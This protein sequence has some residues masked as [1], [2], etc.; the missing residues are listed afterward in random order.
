[1][2]NSNKLKIFNDPIYGFIRIPS[3]LIFNLIEDPYFQRLRRIS[4][5]GLSYLVYP[6]AHH[7]RFHHALGSMHLMQQAIQ[8]LRFKRVAISKEE[9]EGLLIA[10]LLHDIGHGPFSHAMEN[11]IVEGISHEHI[12]LLFMEELN[13]RFNGSLTLAIEIFQGECPKKFLNQLVSSQL[14]MDRL[15]YLKR[16][17]FYTGVAEG[18]INAERLIT[19]LNVVNNELVVEEKGIYSIEKFLMARR[20]MYWQVYLHKTGLVAEQLLIRILKRARQLVVKGLL[21]DCSEPLLF[22]MENKIG[23]P[24]FNTATLDKFAQLDDTDILAAIK[25]WQYHDDFVLAKL[26]EMIIHRKLLTIKMKSKP[27][28]IS[29]FEEEFKAFKNLHGLSNEET[30]FFVFKGE[31]TNRAYNL[32]KQ[33]INILG[34]DGKLKDAAK[35]S[36]HLNLKTLSKKVTKYYI[37]YPKESV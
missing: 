32:E 37:C 16:D 23:K 28:A 21:L 33:N 6:G 4:Q 3:A 18:N 13:R 12:S 25:N 29:K 8:V 7:T 22:F 17:S 10:I 2:T 5:M 27:I 14:D 36:D 19:M 11:S 31:V 1:M 9:E 34:K 26:C 20:F 24:H 15:D 35:A 30:G